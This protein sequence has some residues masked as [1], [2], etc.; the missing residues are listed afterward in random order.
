MGTPYRLFSLKVIVLGIVGN[1][2]G[3]VKGVERDL[4]VDTSPAASDGQL[5][6]LTLMYP[7]VK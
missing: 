2:I 7:A 6:F 4:G 1:Y 3:E 5:M